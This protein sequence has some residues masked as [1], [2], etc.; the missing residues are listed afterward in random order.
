M[1]FIF[2]TLKMLKQN[3]TISYQHKT[4]KTRLKI[5]NPKQNMTEFGT[6]DFLD[7]YRFI[8]N[9]LKKYV[10]K[11]VFPLKIISSNINYRTLV[12]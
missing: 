9:K 8:S 5:P 6:G 4:D 7:H 11:I 3:F 10:T 2:L 1:T 12:L